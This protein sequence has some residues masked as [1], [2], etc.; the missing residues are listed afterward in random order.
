MATYAHM[1]KNRTSEPER[2]CI[3]TGASAPKDALVRFVVGP[4]G[5]IVPDLAE[6]LPGRGIWVAADRAAIDRAVSGKLFARAAKAKVV[7]DEALA[8]RVADLLAKRCQDLVGLAKRSDQLV[9]GYERVLEAMAEGLASVVIIASD[10]GRG[11]DTVRREAG[12]TPVVDCL[13][14]AE[15]SEGAGKGAVSFLALK[16][17]GIAASLLRENERLT[18][19]RSV[20]MD[21]KK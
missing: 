9:V 11:R 7:A 15:L 6:R 10:A 5:T 1:T 20:E 17:G 16:R 19:F 8:E 18:G 3:A 4:D 12:K 21:V 13:T 14:A 2:R